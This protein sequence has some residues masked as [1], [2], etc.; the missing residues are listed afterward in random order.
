LLVVAVAAAGAATA[1]EAEDDLPAP[2]G[3]ASPVTPVLSPRR[4]PGLLA[5]PV[6]DRRLV[7]SLEGVL[8]R[9]PGEACLT[10]TSGGR[11][12][13][14]VDDEHP[15]MPASLEKLVTAAVALQVLGP[16][17]RFRTRVLA[18]AP[19][20]GG[21]VTGDAWLVG[22][23][24]PLLATAAYAARFENQPQV[25]TP[26]EDLADGLVRAGV[27]RI[28]GRL[29][30]DD[31][32]YDADRYP[33]AWPARFATQDVSG[34]LSALSVNDGWATFP[35]APGVRVPDETPAPDPAMQGAAVLTIALAE[36]GVTVADG[37]GSGPAPASAVEVAAIE[38]PPLTEILGEMLRESDNQT[39]E[40]ML[41][42]IAL[43]AGRPPTTVDGAAVVS[44]V[45]GQ[46][47]IPVDTSVI[48]DGSG[49]SDAD[50][51]SCDV[52]QAVLD[53]SGPQSPIGTGLPVAGE[54]GTLTRRFLDSPVTGR[55]R[56]KTG[57]L[58]R[59]TAL[60]GFLETTPGAQLAF[61]YIA[62]LAEADVVDGPDLALQD[63][64]VAALARYPEGPSLAE[65]GPR[66]VPGA[67][68]DP[69][70]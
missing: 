55:L 51:H 41:K 40:L 66:P 70:G 31:S 19:A 53:A 26:L 18:D 49:L 46:L 11:T 65:L 12:I 22:G 56:A 16:D 21:V 44:E 33:D 37:T 39:A 47:G 6:A 69:G 2:V 17:Y 3:A 61:T 14:A 10:V 23:G 27:Q 50:R 1:A 64:L 45:A 67:E 9:Q 36:R 34:P 13:M 68:D 4:V 35:P 59:V 5:A 20:E 60:A 24:D 32:R 63:E 48:A 8:A 43:V 52:F 62:N 7:S 42:E 58:N 38:S 57:T 28:D 15:L 30:G 54:S 29:I 25:R